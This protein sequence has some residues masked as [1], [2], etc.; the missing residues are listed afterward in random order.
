MSN[1][2]QC[3]PDSDSPP[4][5]WI[6]AA[7]GDT[8]GHARTQS[9]EH[10]YRFGSCLSSWK[11]RI[12]KRAAYFRAPSPAT[13]SSDDPCDLL[14][15]VSCQKLYFKPHN[16]QRI[17]CASKNT[18]SLRF[19]LT[20]VRLEWFCCQIFAS[21]RC[22]GSSV[23]DGPPGFALWFWFDTSANCRSCLGS[24]SA[25]VLPVACWSVAPSS[26][27]RL[28]SPHPHPWPFP[29]LPC[30]SSAWPSFC[31]SFSSSYS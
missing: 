7:L 22:K 25:L 20:S 29:S 11:F 18:R 3:F 31:A 24:Y 6:S 2:R 17:V 27:S 23:Y 15:L 4:H 16:K 1:L 9:T 14:I 30:R 13:S 8:T 19:K 5:W 28:N 21:A 26:R 10:Y 12:S